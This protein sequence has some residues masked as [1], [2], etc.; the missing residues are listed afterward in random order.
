MKQT[1]IFVALLLS[2]ISF[3]FAQD[4]DDLAAENRTYYEGIHSVKF[5]PQG[6]AFSYPI[7]PLR[8]GGRL[9]L[10]FDD[11]ENDIMDYAYTIIHCDKDWNRSNL[12]DLEY[13]DGF[14]G[15][16]LEN[17]ST[18]FGTYANYVHYDLFLPNQ[19]LRWTQSGNYLLVIYDQ[20]NDNEVVLTRRFMITEE[21]VNI[22]A[23]AVPVM[24]IGDNRTHQEIDFTIYHEALPLRNQQNDLSVTVLQNGHWQNAI[25]NLK[26]L[27]MYKD[28]LSY[29][30]QGKIVFPG[31][32]EYRMLDLR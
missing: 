6:V 2:S 11:L 21:L 30:Y 1:S 4:F 22:E 8:S 9:H 24:R 3:L 31:L 20:D 27:F 16:L 13:L 19:D 29:D 7:L 12:E 25:D 10:S 5:H 23:K 17:F 26:P 18:S 15:E 28:K 14:T 32:N